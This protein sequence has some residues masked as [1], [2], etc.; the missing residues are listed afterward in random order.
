MTINQDFSGNDASRDLEGIRAE[1]LERVDSILP[2]LARNAAQAEA[3][4]DLPRESFDALVASGALRLFAPRRFGGLEAGYRTYFETTIK[5]AP[6]C[7]SSAWL[8]FIL[9]HGDWQI[10]QMT[11]AV[12]D[13]AWAGGATSKIAVPLAP[14]PGWRAAKVDG[15][16]MITGEWP[17]SSG[18]SFVNSAL[19]GF[20]MIGDDGKPFDNKLGLISMDGVEIKDSWHVAGMAATGS[21]TLVVKDAFIPDS[22]TITLSDLL[23]HRFRT[24]YTQEAQYHMDVGAVFHLATLAPVLGLAKAAFEMTLERITGKPKPM[25]YSFYGD[26]TKAPSTQFAM[27]EASWMID[28]AMEQALATADAIDRQAQMSTPFSSQQRARFAMRAAQGHRLCRGA[29]ERLLDVQGAGSFALANPL[30]RIWRDMSIAT[31][32]GMSVPGL[33]QEVYGRSLLGAQE[34]QMTPIV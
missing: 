16:T 10:G 34:Q 19:I 7:G 13:Q 26:T 33:K 1:V 15:G 21:N 25:T 3:D 17:Y 28:T 18:S 12:Q 23:N 11:R 22:H 14:A 29:V 4:R 2:L 32:H 31:R 24:P 30:Q 5:V 8:C 9:N 27:A 20:P 6:A